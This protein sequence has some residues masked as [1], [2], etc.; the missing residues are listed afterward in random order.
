MI[1]QIPYGGIGLGIAL[2]FIGL[3][4]YEAEATGRIIILCVLALS[5]ILPAIASSYALGVV[6]QIGR[7]VFG[8]CCYVYWK[9]RV[10]TS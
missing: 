10:A 9:Y 4:F 7:L 2:I 3:A 5:F 8:A 1:P 6:C